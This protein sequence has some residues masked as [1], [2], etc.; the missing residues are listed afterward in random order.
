MLHEYTD[1]CAKLHVCSVVLAGEV[2]ALH[3]LQAGDLP[4]VRV[5]VLQKNAATDLSRML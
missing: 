4:Y 2:G 5:P 3:G 1:Y